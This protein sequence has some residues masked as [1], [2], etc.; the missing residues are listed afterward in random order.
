MV[1][2]IL[3]MK[4]PSRAQLP[5]LVFM[6]SSFMITWQFAQFALLTQTASV[7]GTYLLG[8]I[9]S[10]KLRLI[11]EAQEWLSRNFYR[12]NFNFSDNLKT[13]F[14]SK[15]YISK[16]NFKALSLA[17]NY[18]LQF[19]NEMLL[20]SFFASSLISVICIR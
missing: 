11:V 10:K 7:M 1:T 20:T 3:S 4:N 9:G 17:I 5:S 8:F 6:T 2:R 18:V 12:I 14:S 16:S 19:G 15:K 13:K